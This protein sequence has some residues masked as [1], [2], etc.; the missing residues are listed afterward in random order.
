MSSQNDLTTSWLLE[1]IISPSKLAIEDK[2]VAPVALAIRFRSDFLQR[3]TA[4][5]PASTKYLI[6][7]FKN[8]NNKS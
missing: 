8:I 6:K 2:R 7:K 3:R 5:A 4:I 1:L